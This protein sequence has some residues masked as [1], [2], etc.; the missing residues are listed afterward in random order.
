[1][2]P[3][4]EPPGGQRRD[5]VGHRVERIDQRSELV[6][7]F[8]LDAMIESCAEKT[9]AGTTITDGDLINGVRYRGESAIT[10]SIVMRSR[11]GTVRVIDAFHHREKLAQLSQIDY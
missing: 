1:M 11:S 9:Y 7:G 5:L 10:Q 6:P 3:L 8:G 4:P 2:K